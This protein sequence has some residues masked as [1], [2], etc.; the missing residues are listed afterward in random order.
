[1]KKQFPK[2]LDWVWICDYID[3]P[4]KMLARVKRYGKNSLS[5]CGN[6]YEG[7]GRYTEFEIGLTDINGLYQKHWKF[8]RN[9]DGS[10]NCKFI[11]QKH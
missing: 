4:K 1:M 2:W 7:V 3:F 6:V 9:K 8:S 5:A 10:F 11:P